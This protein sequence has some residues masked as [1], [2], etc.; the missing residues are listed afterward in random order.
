[1]GLIKVDYKNLFPNGNLP[2]RRL[3]IKDVDDKDYLEGIPIYIDGD[4]SLNFSSEYSSIYESTPSTL[5]NLIASSTDKPLSGQFAVQGAQIWK[6]TSP[7]EIN[8]TAKLMMNDDAKEDVVKP[9]LKLAKLCLPSLGGQDKEKSLNK[10]LKCLI[11][12]GPNIQALLSVATDGTIGNS[13]GVYT[14]KIGWLTLPNC[15][16]K[17]SSP[18]FSKTVDVDGFP[19]SAEINLS[20]CTVMIPTKDFIENILKTIEKQR[21]LTDDSLIGNLV[22]TADQLSEKIKN[23]L[24][25]STM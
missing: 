22:D 12:P 10:K 17:E 19:I 23:K 24:S 18:T 9:A 1:M 25:Y 13:K 11:P 15:I 14:I 2:E 5:L 21:K 20:I 7:L 3:I 6:S 16:I 8:I 4:I